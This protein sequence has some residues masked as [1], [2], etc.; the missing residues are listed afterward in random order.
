MSI[1]NA[2]QH[3]ATSEQLEDGV[4]E[5]CDFDKQAI[6]ELLTFDSI[7]TLRELHGRADRLAYVIANACWEWDCSTALIGGA[8]FFMSSLEDALFS[9]KIT[10]VYAFSQRVSVEET[11]SDGTVRKVNQ[12]KHLGFVP[13]SGGKE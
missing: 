5:A 6:R 11:Q 4:F 12:F 2:T 9:Y 3:Q 1:L 8:P 7:P 10:P 13:V